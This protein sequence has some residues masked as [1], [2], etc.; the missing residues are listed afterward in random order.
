M[1]VIELRIPDDRIGVLIGKEGEIK[2]RIEEKTG[3]RIKINS[4]T[5]IV[6]VE[7]EDAIGFLKA[8]DVIN[9]IAHGFSPE[10][11][12]K[13]LEEFNVLEI[14]DLTDYVPDSALQRVKGRVI[15][16]EGKVRKNI[17]DMLNVNVSVY[18][19]TVAIIGDPEAANAA[20]E[21]IL[22]LVEGA[23]HSTVQ[24]FLEKKRR[25]LK[26]RSYDWQDLF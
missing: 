6:T 24:R 17:E 3:C 16:K 18:G 25:D 10:V 23:Q 21:A 22:M 19:K 2:K 1:Q 26:L 12:M 20:R 4:K 8:K 11:A 5:G 14:I 9:A 13:L 7:G 15:G